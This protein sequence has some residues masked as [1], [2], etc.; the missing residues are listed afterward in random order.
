MS[1]K[2]GSFK[3]ETENIFNILKKADIKTDTELKMLDKNGDKIISEDEF[4]D[5]TEL[6]EEDK[7]NKNS[8]N[9]TSLLNEQ[10]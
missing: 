4:V 8:Q 10:A 6:I 1:F 7:N 9:S 5:I 2:I 3:I